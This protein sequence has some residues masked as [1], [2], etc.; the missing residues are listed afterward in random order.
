MPAGSNINCSGCSSAAKPCSRPAG[1][2]RGLCRGDSKARAPAR[3]LARDA[4]QL[5]AELA[6]FAELLP[7]EQLQRWREDP[8]QTF[9]QLDASI[10]TRLQQ[11]QAQTELTEELRQCEQCRSDEQLQQRHRR[12]TGRL[13]R[14]TDRAREIAARL[15]AGAAEQPRRAKQRQRRQQQLDAAIQAARQTQAE[16]DRQ[17]NE[18]KLGLT[19]LHSEQQ[20]CRQRQAELEQEREAL[21]AELAPRAS[22]PGLDDATSPSCCTWMTS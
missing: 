17:L 20:N 8:A 12:E 2:A 13:Q 15:P 14:A 4:Q 5:D 3:C 9:M 22:H 11:L 18:S 6:A 7:V 1:R 16:I 19:R 21:N 10:A